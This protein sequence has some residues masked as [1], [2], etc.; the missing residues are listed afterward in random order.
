VAVV[1]QR[2]LYH[3]LHHFD[4]RSSDPVGE[5]AEAFEAESAGKVGRRCRGRLE[6]CLVAGHI[7]RLEL[8]K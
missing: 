1:M 8:Y 7:A 4:S 5:A 3:N 6:K 2:K